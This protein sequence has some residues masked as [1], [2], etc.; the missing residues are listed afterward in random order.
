MR[1]HGKKAFTLAELLVALSIIVLLTLISIPA[2]DPMLRVSSVDSAANIIK[3]ALLHARN[4]A[5]AQRR[6]GTCWIRS[7]P[8]VD[9]GALLPVY[10]TASTLDLSVS[11][12]KAIV[13]D[14]TDPGFVPSGTAT[15]TTETTYSGHYGTSSHLCRVVNGAPTGTATWS[16]TIPAPTGMREVTG[17]LTVEARWPML[18]PT[19]TK[20][21]S[22]AQF[23][24]YYEGADG[25]TSTVIPGCNL[26]GTGMKTGGFLFKCG[27]T[28][29]VELNNATTLTDLTRY[30]TADAI[31]VSGTITSTAGSPTTQFKAMSKNWTVNQWQDAVKPYFV[32][33]ANKTSSGITSTILG[34]IKEN[35]A[36]IITVESTWA[37][38]DDTNTSVTLA[39]DSEFIIQLGDPRETAATKSVGS[40]TSAYTRW[41]V[42][43]GGIEVSL[44]DAVN[45]TKRVW[46]VS[47]TTAGRVAISNADG[48]ITIKVYD[49]QNPT[50]PDMCR[51][52]R[53]YQNTGRAVI[54]RKLTD[55]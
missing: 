42:L 46:P 32:V 12:G 6:T 40:G 24:V 8:I 53:V 18:D 48:Y 45:T 50:N 25:L 11:T 52:I 44:E 4:S 16:F 43:P 41:D 15:W 20:G 13:V 3:N 22:D 1:V 9:S 38:K 49:A 29:R 28:Y 31:R 37:W 7:G 36:N 21:I 19:P 5:I 26:D 35:T 17:M 54:G 30:I 47:F 2:I 39:E 33:I 34:Q 51:Y 14:N 23:R 27:N 10:G 55:L